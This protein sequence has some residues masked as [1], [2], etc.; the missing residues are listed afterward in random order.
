MMDLVFFKNRCV[1][2]VYK[3]L[4]LVLGI[5]Y[6]V[7]NKIVNNYGCNGIVIME[8]RDIDDKDSYRLW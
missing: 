2:S 4:V 7:D 8:R 6:I 1:L 3:M 5:N